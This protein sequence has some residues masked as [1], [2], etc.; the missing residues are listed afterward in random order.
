MGG[1]SCWWQTGGSEGGH[2]CGRLT[3]ASCRLPVRQLHRGQASSPQGSARNE[4]G[5]P[6]WLA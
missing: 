3:A 5:V 1:S 2:R 4:A 6:V